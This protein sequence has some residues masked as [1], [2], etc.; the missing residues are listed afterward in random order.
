MNTSPNPHE[1]PQ[2]LEDALARIAQAKENYVSLANE[3][4]KFLYNYVKGMVKGIDPTTGTHTLQLRRPKDSILRGT[5]VVLVS[6]IVENLRTAL[7]YMIFEL[8][9]LN[10]PDLKE[11]EPQFV[12]SDSKEKFHRQAKTRL[13]HLTAEQKGF[14]E[15]LQPYNGNGMLAL[16]GELAVKGKHRSLLSITDITGL[17]IFFAEITKREEYKDCFVYPMEKGCAIFARPNDKASLLLHQKYDAMA[18]LK[19]MIGHVEDVLR[20]SHCFFQGRPLEL[21]IVKSLASIRQIAIYGGLQCL[22]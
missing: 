2:Q 10:K 20:V 15:Q 18:L 22:D 5:P 16:L 13:R 14:V 7:D 21:T 11:R 1:T 9:A 8:S 3:T 4:E 19:I 6:Q 12:I 17:E